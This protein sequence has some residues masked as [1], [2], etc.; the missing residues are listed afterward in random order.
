M[1]H[2]L[3]AGL[4]LLP[5]LISCSEASQN[6][7]FGVQLA[8]CATIVTILAANEGVQGRAENKARLSEEARALIHRSAAILG[9]EQASAIYEE[10]SKNRMYQGDASLLPVYLD[11]LE[12]DAAKCPLGNS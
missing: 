6:H 5:I 4:M 1:I 2:R 3:P 11:G 10:E 9:Q 8:R 7:E 12:K